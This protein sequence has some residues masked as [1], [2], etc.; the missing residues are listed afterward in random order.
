MSLSI[1]LITFVFGD[2]YGTDAVTLLIFT[3]PFEVIQDILGVYDSWVH[4]PPNICL[5]T[6][7]MAE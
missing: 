3:V 5:Q 7:V 4:L 2:M 1:K 6:I